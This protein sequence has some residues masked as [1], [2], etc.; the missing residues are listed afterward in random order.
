MP[1]SASCQRTK[2]SA[3][4]MGNFQKNNLIVFTAGIL[5]LVV[6]YA[7]FGDFFPDKN[8]QMWHDYS[9]TLPALLDGYF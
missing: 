6:Y 1:E 7:I 2:F 9:E 4:L 5:L 3:V 8:A